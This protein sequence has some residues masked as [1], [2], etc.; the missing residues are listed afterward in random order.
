MVNLRQF[1]F[2]IRTN[3]QVLKLR[4]AVE[5]LPEWEPVYPAHSWNKHTCPLFE[6]DGNWQ[7]H[8]FVR[9]IRMLCTELLGLTVRADSL[10]LSVSYRFLSMHLQL[11]DRY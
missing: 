9:G 4:Y 2:R 5:I 8:C 11:G 10:R 7:V 6:S 3:G 1:A